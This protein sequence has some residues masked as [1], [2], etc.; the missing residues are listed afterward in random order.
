M[1]YEIKK[2]LTAY[3][4]VVRNIRVKVKEHA[5]YR[6]IDKSNNYNFDV[7]NANEIA[8]NRKSNPYKKIGSQGLGTKLYASKKRKYVHEPQLGIMKF[9]SLEEVYH[10]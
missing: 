7:D 9:M 5:Y 10:H 3:A 8:D 6:K 1:E 2:R 4:K